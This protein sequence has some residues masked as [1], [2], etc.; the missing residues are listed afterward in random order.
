MGTALLVEFYHQLPEPR[1]GDNPRK[2]A[3]RFG[4]AMEAFK[5]QTA[6]RYTEGTLQRLLRA[7][8]VESR[9]AA[10]LALGGWAPWPRTSPWPAGCTTRTRGSGTWRPTRC[11]RCGFT[12]TARR[13]TRSCSDWCACVTW[14]K[15]LAG[16]DALIKKAPQFAE[17]CNQRAILH[18]RM[19]EFQKSITDCAGRSN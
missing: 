8:D 15:A 17:A 2:S 1:E 13:T 14:R 11:G 19:K 18:F 16:F 3:Q 6:E 4:A 9:R 7:P 5:K 10:V 12:R